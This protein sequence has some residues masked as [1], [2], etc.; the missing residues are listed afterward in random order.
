[1]TERADGE[2]R[3]LQERGL[4]QS[5]QFATAIYQ[6]TLPR[7]LPETLCPHSHRPGRTGG[8]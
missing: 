3:A 1:M 2:T 4:F 7:C 8:R 6:S 5:Q